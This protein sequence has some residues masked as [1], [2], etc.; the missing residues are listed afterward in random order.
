MPPSQGLCPVRVSASLATMILIWRG[1]GGGGGGGMVVPLEAVPMVPPGLVSVAR[2][3]SGS[4]P[5]GKHW[6]SW[7]A[8]ALETVRANVR[9]RRKLRR[10]NTTRTLGR[11]PNTVTG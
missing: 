6:R 4:L 8:S 7:V 10:K 5:I 2:H 1:G 9:R 11:N 3:V